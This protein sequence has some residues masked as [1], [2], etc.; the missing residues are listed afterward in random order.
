MEWCGSVGTPGRAGV[1]AEAVGLTSNLY[2]LSEKCGIWGPCIT[3]TYT[4]ISTFSS[5]AGMCGGGGKT[6]LIW[7]KGGGFWRTIG[8]LKS[9]KLSKPPATPP[10]KK[11]CKDQE[12]C[13][14]LA[15]V[16]TALQCSALQLA[17]P[18]G[19]GGYSLLWGETEVA[20]AHLVGQI[21]IQISGWNHN[22]F[23][24]DIQTSWY[25]SSHYSSSSTSF[26]LWVL[27]T[28][29]N[30]SSPQFFPL[31]IFCARLDW[32]GRPGNLQ[33]IILL[34]LTAKCMIGL[35]ESES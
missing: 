3:L 31:S 9:Q 23:F 27:L 26:S 21:F 30:L 12:V 19:R 18:Q 25:Q 16:K 17:A 34:V 14:L 13:L 32:S 15:G 2:C 28:L 11:Y 22:F 33:T 10:G 7:G 20:T 1:S 5:I 35:H 29:W 4:L 8:Y 24:W 6:Q